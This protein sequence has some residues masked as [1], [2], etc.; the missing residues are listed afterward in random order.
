MKP[1]GFHLAMYNF[2]LHV[3]GYDAPEVQ[4]FLRREPLNFAAAERAEGYIG[5]S[6]YAEGP[7]P[8][9]WGIQVFPRFIEG[10]GRDSGPSSLS[11]WQDIESLMAFS[12]AGVH[13]EALK[14]ARAWNT[15]NPWPPLVLWWVEAGRRPDW[16][17]GAKKLEWLTD[18]GP[19]PAAFTFK[20]PFGA[21]GE[22]LEID[23]ARVKALTEANL[24]GQRDLLEQLEHMPV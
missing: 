9:S 6:G 2:G 1:P 5:R 20:Q 12:Y 10:S 3:A 8:E 23:R 18:H 24:A 11:L 7:G 4:G 22:P 15:R 19:A 16:D 17:Q 14:N 21:D 13:A